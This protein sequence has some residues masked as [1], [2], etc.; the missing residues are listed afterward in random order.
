M[1]YMICFIEGNT[2]ELKEKK[3]KGNRVSLKE[4]ISK[5]KDK[6]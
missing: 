4:K 5:D 1:M 3:K 2:N 6:D